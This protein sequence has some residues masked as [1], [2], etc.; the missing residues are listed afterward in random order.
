MEKILVVDD[1][2][3]IRRLIGLT[4]GKRYTIIEAENG[5]QAVD[6]LRSE[7]MSAVILDV[8]MPGELDGF[9]VLRAIRADPAL[10]GT[11]VIMVSARGQLSDVDQ[12][13]GI[14]ADA[15]LVKPF[16]PLQLLKVV[17]E[18]LTD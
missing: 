10:N 6:R 4:L 7:M 2:A 12:A 15:Y 17:D 3:D 8:M 16:S 14:G 11:R 18:K 5:R 9:A 1:Q 13:L